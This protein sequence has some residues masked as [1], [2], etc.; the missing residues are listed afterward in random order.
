MKKHIT[1]FLFLFVMIIGFAITTSAQ[2]D[3]GKKKKPPRRD[4]PKIMIPKKPKKPKKNK[5]KKPPRGFSKFVKVKAVSEL[6]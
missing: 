2:S 5:K 6:S 3:K 4:T 1:K